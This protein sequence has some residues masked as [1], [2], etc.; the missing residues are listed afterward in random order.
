MKRVTGTIAT[1]LV[2]VM[3][4]ALPALAS[5]PPDDKPPT[6]V[7]GAGG[8]TAFTGADITI[9]MI[10]LVA[11]AVV[12]IALLVVARRRRPAVE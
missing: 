1:A 5:Y 12:G 8:G 9:G 7:K 3:T 11:L 6:E 4:T 2:A 10:L